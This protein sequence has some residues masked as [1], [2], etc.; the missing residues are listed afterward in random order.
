MIINFRDLRKISV[1]NT[2]LM[3]VHPQYYEVGQLCTT[4]YHPDT[5]ELA[6]VIPEVMLQL[7]ILCFF[8]KY[9][10]SILVAIIATLNILILFSASLP[11][12]AVHWSINPFLF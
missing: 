11:K 8:T 5:K 10:V 7:F 12:A 9:F 4:L 2:D 3:C 1:A 6:E